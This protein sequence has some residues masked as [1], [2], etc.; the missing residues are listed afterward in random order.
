MFNHFDGFSSVSGLNGNKRTNVSMNDLLLDDLKKAENKAT[1]GEFAKLETEYEQEQEPGGAANPSNSFDLSV[2]GK[3]TIKASRKSLSKSPR[4]LLSLQVN[5]TIQQAHKH[6]KEITKMLFIVTVVFILSFLPHLVLM[7][8]NSIRP[9]SLKNM[10][11]A[12][13][14][15]YTIFLRTF[16]INNMAN[17]I[18]YFLCL[19]SFRSMCLERFRTLVGCLKI[20]D[21]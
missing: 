2:S 17:P 16:V 4:N 18:V 6:T 7:V 10:S 21:K 8:M 13:V 15:L 5:D 11:P 3:S 19:G 9:Q 20:K 12:G 14:V 1:T